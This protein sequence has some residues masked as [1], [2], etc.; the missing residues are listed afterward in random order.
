MGTAWVQPLV[1]PECLNE[2]DNDGRLTAEHSILDASCAQSV[3]GFCQPDLLFRVLVVRRVHPSDQVDH[4]LYV[5]DPFV[6]ARSGHGQD[7]LKRAAVRRSNRV[8]DLKQLVVTV[9]QIGIG[10]NLMFHF[11]QIE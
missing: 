11:I 6:V 3:D 4:R 9:L 2:F 10:C 7:R 5:P 1:R 8:H